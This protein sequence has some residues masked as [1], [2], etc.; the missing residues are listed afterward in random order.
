[1]APRL[2][3]EPGN[4]RNYTQNSNYTGPP[5][6]HDSC[7]HPDRW[8]D[9]E[10]RIENLEVGQEDIKNLINT[11]IENINLNISGLRSEL[12]LTKQQ[13]GYQDKEINEIKTDK[14]T[15]EVTRSRRKDVGLGALLGFISTITVLIITFF[16]PL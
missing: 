12:G 7:L 2:K 11:K 8:N 13:N 14:K 6:D 16:T 9:H 10:R 15:K 4:S 5:C 3:D 1:M